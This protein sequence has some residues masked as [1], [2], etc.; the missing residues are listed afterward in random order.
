MAVAADEEE[1]ADGGVVEKI[2]IVAAAVAGTTTTGTA[3]TIRGTTIS[4]TASTVIGMRRGA[5]L[6]AITMFLATR[7]GMAATMP[8][9]M[10]DTGRTTRTL[11]LTLATT[12]NSTA[13]AR[14]S[15]A[16]LLNPAPAI[17]GV[18]VPPTVLNV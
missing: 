2:G 12:A 17:P 1:T 18:R 5:T 4:T 9:V 8:T 3:I 14:A 16:I 7:Q 15:R 11:A 10:H 13:A 6:H